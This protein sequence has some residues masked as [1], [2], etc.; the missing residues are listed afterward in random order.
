MELLCFLYCFAQFGVANE[1]FLKIE[2]KSA[3]HRP[4]ETSGIIISQYPAS[5]FCH[6]MSTFCGFSI[7]G[8]VSEIINTD[9]M[10]PA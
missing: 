3:H 8:R 4:S 10:W 6:Q 2:M 7:Y 1:P 5:F 9:R